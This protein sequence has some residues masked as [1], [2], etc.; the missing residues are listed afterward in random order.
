M[1]LLEDM[2]RNGTYVNGKRIKQTQ[3]KNR[4]QVRVGQNTISVDITPLSGTQTLNSK[5][6]SRD[7]LPYLLELR[8]HIVIK[9]LEAGVTQPFSEERI[10][11]GRRA[12]NNLVLDGDNISRQ[13]VS[14]ERRGDTYFVRDLGSANGTHLNDQ[15]LL[16]PTL[17]AQLCDGDRIRIG[18]FQLTVRLRSQDCIL[19][20]KKL[21]RSKS[22]TRN[23]R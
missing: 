17:E 14:I 22:E 19:N 7:L 13:H 23:T 1:F 15:R 4:D 12:E 9:G 16:A 20:F 5:N 2:S 3:L 10:T 11:I 21:K 8:A 18:D 6:T